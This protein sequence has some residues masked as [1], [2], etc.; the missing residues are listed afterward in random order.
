MARRR[1]VFATRAT[2]ERISSDVL[3]FNEFRLCHERPMRVVVQSSDTLQVSIAGRMHCSCGK[4]V[5]AFSGASSGASLTYT[6]PGK[7]TPPRKERGPPPQGPRDVAGC[8]SGQGHPHDDALVIL[9][10]SS[11]A[12]YPKHIVTVSG[13]S[14]KPVP[15]G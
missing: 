15:G 10:Q 7:D 8:A 9:E 5:A 1:R 3:D 4:V 13:A 6:F 11:A 12:G 2:E 14:R